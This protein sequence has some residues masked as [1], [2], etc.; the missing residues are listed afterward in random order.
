MFIYAV[1]EVPDITTEVLHHYGSFPDIMGRSVTHD[2]S[3]R[4]R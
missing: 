1:N 3:R 2:I 4:G